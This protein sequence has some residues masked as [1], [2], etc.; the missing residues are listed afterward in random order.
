VFIPADDSPTGEALL[1]VAHEIS[2]TTAIYRVTGGGCTVFGDVDGDCQVTVYDV[3]QVVHALGTTCTGCPEDLN[4]DGRVGV[5][6]LLL[7]LR[8]WRDQ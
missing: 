6:D 2:G 3:L 4:E 7:V 1:L 8:A 5:L